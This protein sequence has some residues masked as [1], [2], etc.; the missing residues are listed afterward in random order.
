[1]IDTLKTNIYNLYEKG[2]T[3]N[4]TNCNLIHIRHD[5]YRLW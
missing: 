4:E 2:D 3:P 1:M 5:V